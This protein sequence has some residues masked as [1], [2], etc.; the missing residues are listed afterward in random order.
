MHL[1]DFVPLFAFEVVFLHWTACNCLVMWKPRFKLSFG[2][3]C[4][5][6]VGCLFP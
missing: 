2:W 5:V 4:V 1:N 6:L 3:S